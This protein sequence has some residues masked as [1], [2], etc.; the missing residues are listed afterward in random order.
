MNRVCPDLIEHPVPLD[1]QLTGARLLKLGHDATTLG[2]SHEA[3]G[4]GE[5]FIEKG[6]R[7]CWRIFGDVSNDFV[8]VGLH[9]CGPN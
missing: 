7:R 4:G 8:E 5:N 1:E 3:L 6:K 9:S 2:K